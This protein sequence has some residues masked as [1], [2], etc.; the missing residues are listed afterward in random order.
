MNLE[1]M[2]RLESR[3]VNLDPIAAT[4]PGLAALSLQVGRRGRPP[5]AGGAGLA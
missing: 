1:P 3:L 5:A 4:L 2:V